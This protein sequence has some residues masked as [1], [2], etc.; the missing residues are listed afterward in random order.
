MLITNF[1]GC[2]PLHYAVAK[3]HLEVV[4]VLLEHKADVNVKDFIGKPLYA[5]LEQMVIQIRLKRY[6]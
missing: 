5:I 6:Y 3:G 1:Y 4:K 2:V